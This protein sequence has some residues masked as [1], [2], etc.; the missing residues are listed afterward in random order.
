MHSVLI[1]LDYITI[2]SY[3]VCL[4]MGIILVYFAMT[5]LERYSGFNSDFVSTLLTILIVTGLF[6]A[7]LFY[8]VEHWDYYSGSPSKIWRV[9]EGGL[10][11]YGGLLISSAVLI[12]YCRLKKR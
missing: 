4:A 9:Q 6:G 1:S 10:M 3:G 12:F 2:Y 5:S 7:R 11:F 8:V